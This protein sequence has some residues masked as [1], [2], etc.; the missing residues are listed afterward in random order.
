MKMMQEAITEGQESV[1]VE[2][3]ARWRLETSAYPAVRNVKC[4]CRRGTLVLMGD[5][6]TYYHK[7]IAQ[8]TVRNVLGVVAI[9]NKISVRRHAP[10]VVP[11]RA[12]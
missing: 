7:Q 5:V 11:R 3:A 12:K 8:E 9:I 2:R 10:G 6:I 4:R 1:N